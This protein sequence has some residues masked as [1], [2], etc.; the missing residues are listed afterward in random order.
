V[1]SFSVARH[2]TPGG[3]LLLSRL[4]DRSGKF[5]TRLGNDKLLAILSPTLA[6]YKADA[7]YLEVLAEILVFHKPARVPVSDWLW[8]QDKEFL[9]KVLESPYFVEPGYGGSQFSDAAGVPRELTMADDMPWVYTYKQKYYVDF[10]VRLGAEQKV[11]IPAPAD[12]RFR[13]LRAWLQ[14]QTG[15]IGRALSSKYPQDAAAKANVYQHIADIFF[16]HVDRGDVVPD[17]GGNIGALASADPDGMRLKSDCD[18]L[19]T[20]ATRLLTGA[21]YRAV[22]Y[23]AVVPEGPP[24][25][26]VALLAHPEVGGPAQTPAPGSGKERYHIVNNKQVT[27]SDAVDQEAAIKAALADALAI[28]A[29]KPAVFRVYYENATATGA[30][31]RDLWTTQDRVRRDD[32]SQTPAPAAP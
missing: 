10:L 11:A 12:L 25:H 5:A 28:Y 15:N 7:D 4:T 1:S 2:K 13:T 20:Y 24:A 19:A 6:A 31:T 30:M 8:T 29:G 9:F 16:F 18:V 32:L 22:G 21:G 3:H 27:P 14:A 26:A 17:L 23:L